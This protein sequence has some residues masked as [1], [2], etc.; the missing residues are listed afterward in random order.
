MKQQDR[1]A[2]FVFEFGLVLICAVLVSVCMMG[3]LLARYTTTASG[4]DS[5]RV[6]KFDIT[7]SVDSQAADI[8]LHF[9][10]FSK[11]SDEFAFSVVSE[12]EVA[13]TYDVVV[14]MPA[15]MDYYTWLDLRLDGAEADRV[16]DNVFTFSNVNV[17]APGNPST[18][19]HTLIFSIQPAHVGNPTTLSDVENGTVLITVRAEQVD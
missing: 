2:P 4:S 5:A 6:A 14:T 13:V 10:D 11:L 3:G 15:G 17:L 19:A 18:G 7:N 16:E 12:S 1:K 8:D 9:Y